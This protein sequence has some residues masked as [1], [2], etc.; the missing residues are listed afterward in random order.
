MP[1]IDRLVRK[2]VS[3][4]AIREMLPP[5][6]HIG[7]RLIAPWLDVDTDDVIFEY[8][9]ETSQEGLAPA[10]AEDAEAELAQKDD[11]LYGEGRASLIDWALKDK[12]TASDVTRYRE[13]LFIQQQLAG[14]QSSLNFNYSR[15]HAQEFA[16]KVSRDDVRRRRSLDN[17][18]EKTIMGALETGVVA[19]NDGKIKFSVDFGRP[20]N[21]TAE[22]P[23]GGLWG[24]AASDPIG[25]LIA[26]KQFMFDL[27]G[28]Y[29]DRGIISTKIVNSI[30]K[31][32]RFLAAVGVP[33]LG[34][35]PSLTLDPNYLGLAGYTPDGAL[36]IV[37][38]AT[39]ITFTV[40]DA[41]YRTRPIGSTTATN[42]RFTTDNLVILYPSEGQLGE[43]NDTSLGFA[44][45]LTAP[46]PEGNWQSG[47][48]EWEQETVDPWMHVRGTGVKAFPVF[49]YME[50]TYTMQVLA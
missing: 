6:E 34:G 25:D 33:V 48:Y 9:A 28:I 43:I 11:L 50:Y 45:T 37:E 23:A 4:G 36:R 12:Y 35:T 46:H 31:S 24:I 3:L 5:Q 38:A 19:Y 39:G 18:L 30:W 20:A 7:L 22:A 40:Y 15:R 14:V 10:R 41:V 16:G 2:E 17:R 44:K 42:V 47:F 21:Q 29:I 27:Y 32:D 8:I 13:D 1:A 49:P 26:V